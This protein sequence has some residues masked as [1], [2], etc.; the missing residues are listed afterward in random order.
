AGEIRAH[1]ERVHALGGEDLRLIGHSREQGEK[2]RQLG[3]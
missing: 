2:L 3:G 1:R